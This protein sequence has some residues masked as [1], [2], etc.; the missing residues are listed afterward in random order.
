MLL[1]KTTIIS[2]L[3][4]DRQLKS[5]PTMPNPNVGMNTDKAKEDWE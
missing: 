1:W 3:S 4:I 2:S 5:R